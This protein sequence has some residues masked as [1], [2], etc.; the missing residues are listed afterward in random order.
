MFDLR[1]EIGWQ[2]R[3]FVREIEHQGKRIRLLGC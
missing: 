2:E 3:L 1:K